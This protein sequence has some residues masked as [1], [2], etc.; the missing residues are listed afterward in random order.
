[1]GEDDKN[2]SNAIKLP[3]LNKEKIADT[4]SLMRSLSK[5]KTS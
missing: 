4:S 3:E 1:M 2:P 5:A